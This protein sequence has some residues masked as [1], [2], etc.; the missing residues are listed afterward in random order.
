MIIFTNL[1]FQFFYFMSKHSKLKI[2]KYDNEYNL[3]LDEINPS[4][5]NYFSYSFR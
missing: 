2:N 4:K 3:R 1:Y 5:S